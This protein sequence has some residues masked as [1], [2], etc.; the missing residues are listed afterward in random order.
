V[1]SGSVDLNFLG[2]ATDGAG[3]SELYL[4]SAVTSFRVGGN[5]TLGAGARIIWDADAAGNVTKI[6]SDNFKN[7]NLNGNGE[8]VVDLSALAVEPEEIILIDNNGSDAINGTFASTNLIGSSNYELVYNGGDGNDVALQYKVSAPAD[9]GLIVGWTKAVH[10]GVLPISEKDPDEAGLVV[11]LQKVDVNFKGIKDG[12][13]SSDNTYGSGLYA[14]I[15]DEAAIHSSTSCV[16]LGVDDTMEIVVSN[17]YADSS[18]RLDMVLTDWAAPFNDS[19]KTINVKYLHGDLDLADGTLLA[20]QDG[21]TSGTG[22]YDF[23][24]VDAL[25]T[26]H[27][28]SERTLS[29][30][31]YAVFEISFSTNLF[32]STGI[33]L[34]DNVGVGAVVSSGGG[35]SGYDEWAQGYPTLIG[36]QQD[37]D[38]ND[39]LTNLEEFGLGGNPTN[40]ADIGYEP[41]LTTG[42]DYIDYTHVRRTTANNG[43]TYWLEQDDDLVAAP[44]WTNSGDYVIIATNA[45]VDEDEFEE[46]VNRISTA[47]KMN[48]FIRLVIE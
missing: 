37:D 14:N 27:S 48:E 41:V 13:G 18:I 8:L 15:A 38:D 7:I 2:I 42:T 9:S 34:V 47:G 3:V 26:G 39:G 20:T 28:V 25:L 22:F 24:D 17:A 32:G 31:E 40:S 19:P 5:L 10:P 16:A 6:N 43:L 11:S 23:N 36:G 44:G 46:I 35:L 33:C 1:N 12:W 21:T 4:D 30:G 29:S 45:I